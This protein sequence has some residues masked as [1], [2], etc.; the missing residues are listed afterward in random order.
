MSAQVGAKRPKRIRRPVDVTHKRQPTAGELSWAM[1]VVDALGEDF[2]AA[3]TAAV[4]EGRGRPG[5]VP[6][7]AVLVA[8]LLLVAEPGHQFELTDVAAQLVACSPEQLERLGM[9]P[10]PASRAYGRVWDKTNAVIGAFSV[11]FDV[12]TPVGDKVRADLPWLVK[13]FA[14]AS[15]DPTL[16]RSRARAVDGTD[17]ETCGRWLGV[18]GVEYDGETPPDT[19]TDPEEHRK[20]VAEAR[21]KARRAAFEMG[22][23]GR[24]IYTRDADAKAGHRSANS[25]HKAGLYIGYEAHPFTQ[26]RDITWNGKPGELQLGPDVPPYVTNIILTPAGAH[27]SDAV[28]PALIAERATVDGV[29]CG[30]RDVSWD[31]GYSNNADARTHAPLRMHG[32]EPVIDLTTKQRE[33]QPVSKDVLWI[34]GH[35]FSTHTPEHLRS[36][37]R[38]ER[39][40]S[41][42]TRAQIQALY[43]ERA[44]WR[45]SVHG[46]LDADGYLR[47]RCPFCTGRL[48]SRQLAGARRAAKNAPLVALPDGVTRCCTGVVRIPPEHLRAMQALQ[49]PFGTT[50]HS[51]AYGRR[52][53][54]ETTN[55]LLKGQYV[56]L[57][58]KYTK[59]MGLAKRTFVMAFLAAGL[60]RYIG[61]SWKEK[62]AVAERERLAAKATRKRRRTSTLSD[63]VAKATATTSHRKPTR[64]TAAPTS[65]PNGAPPGAPRPRKA[66]KANR[67]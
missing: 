63:I 7:R 15:Q 49:I 5:S 38:P 1:E 16:P 48:A 51:T 25:E 8:C 42:E 39:N 2:I 64:G 60:N 46:G 58:R 30:L 26:V 22:P 17:W 3:L 34:D 4:G 37:P 57:D 36:L 18:S 31:R 55:S 14:D 35:P 67:S 47:M 20:V 28:V 19:D 27:R 50:A 9:E 23:D 66:T 56:N 62:R 13:A 41:A 45:Y 10:L 59:L 32:I 12:T 61:R 21:R 54:T 53:L 11:G 29:P 44:R 43:N 33:Y 40:D 52:S 6:A 65:P 24:P